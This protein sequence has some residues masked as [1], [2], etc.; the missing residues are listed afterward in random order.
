MLVVELAEFTRHRLRS[1][2]RVHD[3]EVHVAVSGTEGLAMARSLQ[4]QLVIA[5][6]AL[7][8][9]P[10]VSAIDAF[11]QE[12]PGAAVV[13][14]SPQPTVE[15][16]VAAIHRGA[17]DYLGAHQDI[18]QVRSAAERALRITRARRQQG[19]AEQEV[20]NQR[21][22]DVLL[23]QS[24]R[25]LEALEQVVRVASTDA[26]AL[27]IGASGTGK[28]VVARRIHDRS[29][30]HGKPFVRV[31]C[32][33]LE[34]GDLERELFGAGGL[35]ELADGGTLFVDEVADASATVQVRLLRVLEDRGFRRVG[36]RE[37]VRVNVRLIAAVSEPLDR[38]VAEGRFRQDLHYR[39]D[40]FPIR[41]PSLQERDE[42]IPLL[43]RH[44]LVDL[45]GDYGLE[46]PSLSP[47]AMRAILAY[48]WPGNVRQLRAMCERWLISSG[49][50]RIEVAGLP[51]DLTS[52][53]HTA[54]SSPQSVEVDPD[55]PL[56]ANTARV[57]EEVERTYLTQVLRRCGGH[58]GH[59][60]EASGVTRRTLYTKMRQYGLEQADF[61]R[62][63]AR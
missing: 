38:A 50:Q 18:E 21:G 30:R 61:S 32:G 6:L 9:M 23:T 22:A 63:N 5:G 16:A 2:L 40:V 4:P 44:F 46:P 3:R 47:D 45:A 36:G 31:S 15:E 35:L 39:L 37:Q 29:K 19:L 24:A 54:E 11:R 53:Q 56:K 12:L 41:L 51:A 8:D 25:M 49:G 10:G 26:T 34:P 17:L 13:A 7:P 62:S 14:V 48:S 58:L 20:R 55:L 28:E 60:A 59:T 57:V 33:A 52:S 1:A 43:M 42:D 27:V